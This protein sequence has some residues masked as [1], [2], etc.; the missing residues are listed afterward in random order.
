MNTIQRSL[1]KMF[2]SKPVRKPDTFR[3]DREWA[4]PVAAKHGIEIERLDFGWNV[5]PP[6]ALTQIPG[7]TDPFDGDH[8][9][10]DWSEIKSMVSQYAQDCSQA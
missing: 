7:W 10:H 5:W 6:K 1:S 8:F 9:C 3:K 2:S 4:K